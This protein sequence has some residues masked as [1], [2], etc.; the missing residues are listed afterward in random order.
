MVDGKN[1]ALRKKC[2]YSELFRFVFS[3]IC[4]EYEDIRSISPYSVQMRVN[5][6]Q[7]YSEYGHF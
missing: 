7:N 6:D 2:P 3:G 4:T 5:T 1:V